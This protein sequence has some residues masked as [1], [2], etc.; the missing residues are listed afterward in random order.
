MKI[1]TSSQIKEIDRFTILNEPISSVELM[2]RAANRLFAW[3]VKHF[4][5]SRRVAVFAGSGNNGGDGLALA[6]MLSET[7]YRVEVNYVKF[8]DKTSSEWELNFQKIKDNKEIK[9]NIIQSPN[10]FPILDKN[11]VVIDS[12]FGIGLSKKVEGLPRHVIMKINDSDSTTISI[13]IPSGLFC[14]DNSGN[15]PEAIIRADYTLSLQFPKLAF[16]FAENADF[17]GKWEIIPIGLSE[18]AIQKTQTQFY[19]TNAADILPVLRKRRTFDHKGD[20]G[21]GLLA[22]GS[23]GKIG[24]ATLAATAALRSGLGL[25]TVH[26]PL[27]GLNIMQT[28]LPEAMVSCDNADDFI[29]FINP[30]T[31]IDAAALGPGLG[32]DSLTGIAMYDFLMG[33]AGSVVLDADALNILALNKNRFSLLRSNTVITPHPKEFDRLVGSSENGF[34]RFKK[35]MEFAKKYKCIVVLKGAFTSVATSDGMVMFNSVGNPGMATAGSGD[36]LTG[37]ILSLLAQGYSAE[38]AA[39]TGVFLHGLAG[40]IAAEKNCCESLIASDIINNI[41]S[42][43]RRIINN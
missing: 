39:V 25:L 36:V 21:H 2:E 19:F 40:D 26:L 4:D 18:E 12:I 23:K 37:I 35:Q 33:F 10:D 34:Q 42:A 1:F 6:R 16:M 29:T 9:L 11:D 7:G 15:N 8:S 32:I 17:V 38:N 14:D 30:K 24:A 3:Y 27:C 5:R 41:A 20:Y 28:A 22:A 43:Y 31:A 13:D